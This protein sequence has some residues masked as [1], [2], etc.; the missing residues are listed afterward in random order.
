MTG[1]WFLPVLSLSLVLIF[2]WNVRR[3]LRTGYVRFG[4]S[5]VWRQRDPFLFWMS[6]A[7]SGVGIIFMSAIL[8]VSLSKILS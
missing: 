6:M 7:V 1:Q 4:H 5:G 8:I 3:G 2:A